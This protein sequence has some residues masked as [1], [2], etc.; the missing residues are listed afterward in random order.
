MYQAGSR[1]GRSNAPDG[2]LTAPRFTAS[3]TTKGR[4]ISTEQCLDWLAQ[5]RAQRA[6]SVEQVPFD[7]LVGWHFHK[8]TGNL[9]HQSGRFFTIE[10]LQVHLEPARVQD[11]NQPIIVQREIGILGI[12]VK[13]FDGV[14]HCLMQAKMEPGNSNLVQLSPTVQATRSN[15]TGVHKG[16][17]I[18]YLEHFRAPRQGTVLVDSLQSEQSGWFLHKRNRNIVVE[19]TEDIELLPDFAWLTLYQIQELLRLDNVVNMDARTVLSIMPFAPPEAPAE[20]DTGFR[21]ALVRSLD[22]ESPTV[23]SVTEAMSW[24]TENKARYELTQQRI[25]LDEVDCW[26]R[27]EERIAHQDGGFFS[28]VGVAVRAE[29]REVGSWTQPLLAP[30]HE[31]LVAFLVKKIDG[32]L[33]IL[34]Q[35]RPSAGAL[36]IVEVAP[37]LQCTPETYLGLPAEHRPRFLDEV[38]AVPQN[39]VRYVAWQS[40]EGGRFLNAHIRYQVIEVE[41]DF[42]EQEPD[43]FRWLTVHQLSALVGFGVGV[44]VEARSLLACLHTLW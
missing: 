44:N 21:A 25:R 10:G 40:E 1:A 24:L 5:Q 38:I 20:Q 39:R 12:L 32:V 2:A 7:Q 30:A 22:A 41:D 4:L 16:K 28:I 31:G 18:P 6:F 15:Y 29:N 37:T 43:G 11:W 19:T 27:D 42:P 26:H 34:I 3:A 35:A 17:A 9:V 33:H 23:H 13:E 36:D 14:L 8:D